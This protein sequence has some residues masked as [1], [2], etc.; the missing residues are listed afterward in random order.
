MENDQKPNAEIKIGGS[1]KILPDHRPR[2]GINRNYAMKIKKCG[3]IFM[4]TFRG[5]E[6]PTNCVPVYAHISTYGHKSWRRTWRQKSD[7]L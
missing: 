3:V 6:G 4:D 5:S 1:E 2:D 7:N